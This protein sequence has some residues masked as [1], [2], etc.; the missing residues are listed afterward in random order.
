MGRHFR[1]IVIFAL[2]SIAAAAQA[3]QEWMRLESES[4]DFSV[5]VPSGY[6]V[7]ED[8]KGYEI[9]KS[10]S[11]ALLKVKIIKLEDIKRVMAFRD[12]ATVLIESYRT[13]RLDDAL[14]IFYPGLKAGA[15]NEIGMNSFK[16]RSVTETNEVSYKYEAYFGSGDHMYHILAAARTE[17]NDALRYILSSIR[18]NGEALLTLKSD[19]EGKAI[20]TSMPISDL[21]ETPFTFEKAESG[22]T[23]PQDDVRMPVIAGPRPVQNDPSRLYIVDKPRA[24]YTPAARK[25][26]TQ[27]TIKLRVTFGGDGKIQKI[28]ELQGLPNGLTEESVKAARMM[29]F[30]P[31]EKDGNPVTVEKTIIYSFSIY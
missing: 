17:K 21:H 7:I 19:L 14:E 23:A 10:F 11:R 9:A 20:E 15:T 18:F 8:K 4:K 5:S 16:G 30:L 1:L 29:R 28:I 25:K 13:N 24:S 3:S 2:L 12:G 22:K 27:G 6:E 26:G 31:Q